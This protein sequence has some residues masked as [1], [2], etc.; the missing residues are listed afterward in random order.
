MSRLTTSSCR[1]MAQMMKLW[2]V[3]SVEAGAKSSSVHGE[4]VRNSRA[5]S[6]L[7]RVHPGLLRQSLTSLVVRLL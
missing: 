3:P 1:V 7:L 4:L 6:L 5:T 2:M